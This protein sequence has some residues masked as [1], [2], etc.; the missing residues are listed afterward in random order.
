MVTTEP[1]KPFPHKNGRNAPSNS[2]GIFGASRWMRGLIKPE[3]GMGLCYLDW[4]AQELAIAASLSGD[5]AMLA[6]TH[7]TSGFDR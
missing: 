4:S 6:R 7:E 3:P 2:K 1:A 5:P